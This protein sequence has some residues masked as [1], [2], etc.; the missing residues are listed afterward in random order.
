MDTSELIKNLL[1][2]DNGR[3]VR[4][5][6]VYLVTKDG[7]VFSN[8]MR[9]CDREP[10]WRK[11]SLCRGNGSGRYYHV[12]MGSKQFG[13]RSVLVHRLVM[14]VFVGPC[15]PGLEVRHL[16]G[17]WRNNCLSNLAYG[18]RQQNMADAIGHNRTCKGEKNNRSIFTE[19][20]VL[21]IKSL[22]RQGVS[23]GEIAQKFKCS[24]EAIYQIRSGKRWGWLVE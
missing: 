7:Q 13:R 23:I 18:T 16:D 5:G 22:L 2:T 17:D 21:Q 4:Y 12:S 6:N 10:K 19:K 1:L 20:N 3:L 11:L 9:Q 14:E 15:H 8:A 24:K